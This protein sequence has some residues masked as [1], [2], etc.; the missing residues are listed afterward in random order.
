[1]TGDIFTFKNTSPLL[2]MHELVSIIA[3]TFWPYLPLLI[4]AVGLR[5]WLVNLCK[6]NACMVVSKSLT[7]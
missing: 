6:P 3:N 1:M 7:Y 5:Y 2:A 4:E